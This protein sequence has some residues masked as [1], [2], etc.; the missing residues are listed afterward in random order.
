MDQQVLYWIMRFTG[1][2]VSEAAGLLK[3]DVNL[4][5]GVINVR[6]NDQRPLKNE[7]RERDLPIIKPLADKLEDWLPRQSDGHLFLQFFDSKVN[8]WG[9]KLP[10]K[11]KLGVSPKA[12]RDAVA[13]TLRD[14]DVNERVI[15]S[16]LGHTPQTSTGQYGTAS[17]EAKLNAL[18]CLVSN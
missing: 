7:Y 13:T 5:Q 10:W 1:T 8:R 6:P 2:H 17:M 14:H 18:N 3:D 12:C 15:G 4:D 11:R 9:H 16:I